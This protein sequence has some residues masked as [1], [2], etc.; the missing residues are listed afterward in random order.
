[1]SQSYSLAMKR[2]PLWPE[3]FD[4]GLYWFVVNHRGLS[5]FMDALGFITKWSL[6]SFHKADWFN[7]ILMAAPRTIEEHGTAFIGDGYHL[8]GAWIQE[9]FWK[10]VD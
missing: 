2:Q 4:L 5:I 10:A 1:M 7:A 9:E 6:I 8:D 3:T